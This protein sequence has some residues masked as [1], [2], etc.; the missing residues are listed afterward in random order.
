MEASFPLSRNGVWHLSSVWHYHA[1]APCHA[2]FP[3][4]QD[5]LAASALSFGNTS[6]RRLPFRAET[7]ALNAH[8]NRQAPFADSLTPTLHCYKN[9]ISTLATL[10]TTQ[11]RLHFASSI[12]RAPCHRSSTHSNHSLSSPSH[13]HHPFTQWHPRWWTS[14]HSFASWTTYQHVNSHKKIFWNPVAPRGVIK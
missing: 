7:K 13:A 9:I 1:T 11:S 14:R 8:H 6:S 4:S 3:W 10:L 5:E 12:T 2:S